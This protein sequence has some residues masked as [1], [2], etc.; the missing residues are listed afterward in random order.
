M[1]T[2]NEMIAIYILLGIIAT[3]VISW[4]LLRKTIRTRL[5]V[6]KNLKDDPDINDYLVIFDW[7][8]KILYVPSII[9]SIA[10]GL[11][12]LLQENVGA[13]GFINPSVIG[14]IWFAVVFINVLVEEYN[15]SLK[16]LLIIIV[17]AGFFLLWLHLLG[18]V[19]WFFKLLRHIALTISSTGFFLI[20]IVALFTILISWLRGLFFYA[21]I[22]PNYINLQEGPT[23]TG[24]QLSR[25]DYN[26]VIDTSDFLERLMG[27]GRIII[28]FKDMQKTPLVFLVWQIRQKAQMIERVRGKFAIDLNTQSL[29]NMQYQQKPME[30]PPEEQQAKPEGKNQE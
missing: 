10:A 27:F 5:Q 23:E 4:F 30:K 17:T 1:W 16:L 9:V 13:L 2:S 6:S 3:G 21:A 26:T 7:S 29:Q 14:G 12:M 24:Q 25:E 8:H 11:I 18:A 28:I 19:M 15:I 22:T 20:S